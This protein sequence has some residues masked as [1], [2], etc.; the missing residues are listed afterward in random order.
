MSTVARTAVVSATATAV[1]DKTR[2][3]GAAKAA[4]QQQQVAAQEAASP[5]AEIGQMQE[6]LATLQAQ[7]AEVAA[8][9]ESGAMLAQ[10]QQLAE[11]KQSGLLTEEE[12]SAAKARL[13][14]G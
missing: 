9:G 6:Q 13:L 10:L 5:Q 4:A 11:M 8:L 2:A 7:Q 12:F 14:A 3:R 1:S